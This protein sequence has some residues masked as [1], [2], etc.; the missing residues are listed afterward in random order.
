MELYYV[1]SIVD[2]NVSETLIEI[3]KELKLSLVLVRL[4]YG[5]ATSEHLS[6]H[7]LEPSEKAI[8]TAVT[9]ADSM[10][11][12]MKAAKRQMFIDIPGNGIMMAMPL[13]SVCGGKNLAYLTEGQTV[14]GSP[15]GMMNFENELIIVI[16]KEGF[17]DRVMDAARSAG[18]TGGTLLHAKGTGKKKNENFYGISLAEEK[19]VLYILAPSSKKGEIM[20][21]INAECG[22][23]TSIGSICISLPVSE[24]AG[25]RKFEEE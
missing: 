20:K 22:P 23:Q 9:T 18:A 14:G 19:D 15:K 21:K 12:L 5:S 11:Q 6:L 13:K 2:R 24:V 7:D 1:M 3:H 8:V 25:I 16:L 4:G 10:K 17:S